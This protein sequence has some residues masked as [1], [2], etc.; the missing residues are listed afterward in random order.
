M[1]A[2]CRSA[3]GL[4]DEGWL[5]DLSAV[6]CC[7]VTRGTCFKVGNHIILRPAGL[8]GITG[9]VRWVR[10]N[11]CGIEFSAPL[12][13]AVLDHLCKQFGNAVHPMIVEAAP[14]YQPRSQPRRVF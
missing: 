10:A 12:Y 9:T 2:S 13:G 14:R 5:E 1:P 3:N 11:R 8:E 7:F 4:R 6:G